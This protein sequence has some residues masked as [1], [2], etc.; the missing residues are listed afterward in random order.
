MPVYYKISFDCG[1]KL[2]SNR[3]M[4]KNQP[5]QIILP[6]LFLLTMIFQGITYAQSQVTPDK[7][8]A[9]LA[10]AACV[11]KNISVKTPSVPVPELDILMLIDVTNSMDD[12]IDEVTNSAQKVTGNI[13]AFAPD[14]RF[15]VATFSDYPQESLLSALGSL[16]G[17]DE[18][19]D[20]GDYPWR[21]DQEFTPE[22]SKIKTALE[23]ITL[24]NGG[25]TPESYL[26]ALYEAQS[27]PWRN[28]AR[29]LVILFGDSIP[30]DPDPG[31]DSSPGTADDLSFDEIVKQL[32]GSEITV[33]SIYSNS[34]ASPFYEALAQGTSGQAFELTETSQVPAAIQSLILGAVASINALTLEPSSAGKSWLTWTPDRFENIGGEQTRTFDLNICV[35]ED[36]EVGEYTFDLNIMADGTILAPIPVTVT[37]K[38]DLIT[39]ILPFLWW[40][41]PLLLVPLL[42]LGTWLFIKQQRKTKPRPGY[43]GKLGGWKGPTPGS[44]GSRYGKNNGYDNE[45]DRPHSSSG[46][47]ITH[48][49]GKH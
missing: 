4:Q 19:G 27:L 23:N 44:G 28:D 46:A 16:F 34:E 35:P 49:Q 2:L 8:E 1:Q 6:G 40:L 10:P 3:I 11:N 7:I 5:W 45:P 25:D 15:A 24:L 36:T 22:Q 12:V 48:G 20:S 29:R 13:Q 26:R 21:L 30:H 14:T 37:V 18:Y 42:L 32:A 9:T 39:A 47:D 38:R 31:V 33:L 41:I 43:R 17:I